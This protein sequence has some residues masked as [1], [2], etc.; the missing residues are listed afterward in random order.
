MNLISTGL[1][2]RLLFS[3][4]LGRV[5]LLGLLMVPGFLLLQ[6]HLAALNHCVDNRNA[7]DRK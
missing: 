5:A 3:G 6:P 1:P 4:G 7:T 2:I